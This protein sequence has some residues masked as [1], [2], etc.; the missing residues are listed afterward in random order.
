MDAFDL[1]SAPAEF[2]VMRP[3]CDVMVIFTGATWV[4]NYIVT[5]RQIFRDRVCGMPLACLC[6]NIAWEITVVL[7]HRPPYFLLDVFFAMW[8][9]V[10]MVI[11]HGS[12]KVSMEEQLPSPVMH[13]YLPLIVALT[14][15]CFI[16]G[17]HALAEMLGPTKAVWWGGMLSQLVMSAECLG[18][19]LHRGSTQ[20]ASWVMWISRVLGSYSAIAG[21]FLKSWFWPQQWGWF[22]NA[23]TRWITGISLIMDVMYGCIFWYIWQTEKGAKLKK[24]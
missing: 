6:C 20:G 9:S 19:L 11:V 24:A 18:Q 5:V 17:Y 21:V 7:V 15:L 14:I 1:S 3:I 8:L 13:K 16:S 12:V 2:Q 22:D 10:N 23:L 4:I